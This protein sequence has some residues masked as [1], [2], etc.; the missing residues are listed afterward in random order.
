MLSS[1]LLA[2]AI[3]LIALLLPGDQAAASPSREQIRRAG[4]T[5]GAATAAA[6]EQAQSLLSRFNPLQ[7][8]VDSIMSWIERSVEHLPNFPH[9]HPQECVKRSI[10]EAHNEPTKY[11]AIGFI[12]RLLF[13]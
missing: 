11:G 4:S 1:S 6:A 12:L 5:G 7:G 13:P 3:P 10:C 8:R 2:G 9:L